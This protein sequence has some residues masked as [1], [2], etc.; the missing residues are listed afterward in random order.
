MR[1]YWRLMI[2]VPLAGWAVILAPILWGHNL[3][4]ITNPR[5]LVYTALAP[6]LV[7]YIVLFSRDPNH[8]WLYRF[9]T[10]VGGGYVAAIV[11][12]YAIS[13]VVIRNRPKP[14]PGCCSTCGY[15][16][17]A[18]KERCPECGTPIPV[19]ADEE[20]RQA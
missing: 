4:F 11:V 19:I 13:L 8:I 10:P 20:S 14:M 6:L 2:A 7:P 16:L 12:F 1:W 3:A 15:D 9:I 5:G 18:S 17:R